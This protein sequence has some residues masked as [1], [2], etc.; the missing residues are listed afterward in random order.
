M[1]SKT[2]WQLLMIGA[3]GLWIISVVAGYLL[4]PENHLQAWSFF[5][6]L[7]ILHSAELF[8]AIPIGRKNGFSVRV[9]VVK[10]LLF[11]FTWWLPVKKGIIEK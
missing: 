5:L 8:T 3:I 6:G 1:N 4:F 2:F 9:S 7:V 11:G 10:T